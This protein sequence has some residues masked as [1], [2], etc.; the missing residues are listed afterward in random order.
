M[1]VNCQ[2]IFAPVV[3]VEPYTDFESALKQINSSPYGLQTGLFTRDSKLIFDA[4][5]ELEVGA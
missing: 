5:N 3:T 2:E 1:K 4:Y